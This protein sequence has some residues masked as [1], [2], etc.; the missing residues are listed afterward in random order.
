[1]FDTRARARF[2][3]PDDGT[4]RHWGRSPRSLAADPDFWRL[5]RTLWATTPRSTPGFQPEHLRRWERAALIQRHL[6]P[7]LLV[8][9]HSAAEL[10]GLPIAAPSAPW[11]HVLLDEPLPRQRPAPVLPE[12]TSTDHRRN[13]ATGHCL[14]RQGIGLPP[15]TGPWECRVTHPVETLLKCLPWL[16]GWHAVAAVDHL[17]SVGL[18]LTGPPHPT[19]TGHLSQASLAIPRGFAGSRRLAE[20][21]ELSAADTWSPMET[22]LRLAVVHH[23]LPV[24]VMNRRVVVGMGETFYL[25]LAWPA[26]RVA[27]EYNGRVH[28]EDRETYGDE[29]HRL[30]L[31]EEAGWQVRVLVLEDL[32][33]HLRFEAALRW[34]RTRLA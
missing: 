7:S 1:M 28:Y 23:D 17:R 19:T 24:P 14:V 9:H 32:R 31:L 6:D 27:L 29:Q 30:H 20:A 21:I 15:V 3:A 5:T 13:D 10:W 11:T 16:P 25:D 2:P 26:A 4:P 18:Q 22:L 12:L 34:L 8:S 33:D